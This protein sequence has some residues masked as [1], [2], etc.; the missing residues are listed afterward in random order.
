MW[1]KVCAILIV[2][3]LE[4]IA[5]STNTHAL[6]IPKHSNTAR[7]HK[8]KPHETGFNIGQYTRTHARAN[9]HIENGLLFIFFLNK[10]SIRFIKRRFSAESHPKSNTVCARFF[11]RTHTSWSYAHF[12]MRFVSLLLLPPLSLPQL[13]C[14]LDQR[15]G[16]NW[17]YCWHCWTRR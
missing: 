16:L 4:F 6:T 8:L 2:L 15:C 3:I 5:W 7:T 14:L 12:D 10:K 1:M 11:T 13:M 17:P 9:T